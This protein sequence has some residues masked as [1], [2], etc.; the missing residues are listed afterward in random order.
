MVDA[1]DVLFGEG[2]LQVAVELLGAFE[3]RPEGLFD[4][5]PVPGAVLLAGEPG[6]GD[7][8]RGLPEE[9][10]RGGQVEEIIFADLRS[11]RK[12]FEFLGEALVGFGI[13]EFALNIICLLYTSRCV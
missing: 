11:L 13:V 8:L 9:L 12:S 5:Q 6:G 4:D 1:E 2:A 7:I 3:I 10:G